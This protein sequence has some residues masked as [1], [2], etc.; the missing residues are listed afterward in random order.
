ML[1]PYL[2][3]KIFFA[4]VMVSARPVEQ[5]EL[6]GLFYAVCNQVLKTDQAMTENTARII[7]ILHRFCKNR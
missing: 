6:C 1:C 2:H 3:F 7:Y 5:S 4:T